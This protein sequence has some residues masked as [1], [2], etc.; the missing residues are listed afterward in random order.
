MVSGFDQFFLF[1]MGLNDLHFEDVSSAVSA[2]CP[3]RRLRV[4]NPFQICLVATT[5]SRTRAGTAL[6][7]FDF[8]WL[9]NWYLSGVSPDP[10][11]PKVE[12]AYLPVSSQE[13]SDEI[14]EF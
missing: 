7:G 13:V 1:G 3:H 2:Q 14:L 11:G 4:N 8:R 9:I 10:P 5:R 6:M 12:P